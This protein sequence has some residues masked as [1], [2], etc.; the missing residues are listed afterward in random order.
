MKTSK[1]ALT[2]ACAAMVASCG[3]T[4]SGGAPTG[5][6]PTPTPSSTPTP[7]PTSGTCSL[8]S[9][10]SWTLAQL[11]EWYLFPDLLDT[12]VNPANYSSVQSYIDALVKPARD[13]SRDRYFTYLTSIAEENAFFQQGAS[14]GFGIRL[15]Y[16]TAAR[17]VYVIEAFENAP[18]LGQNMDRG[19]ELL[20]IGT[21]EANLQTVNSLMANGGP[22]AVI[23]ALGPD[24]AGTT[25]VIRIR[26][27]SGID[28]TISLSK[29]EYALDPVSDRYGFKIINDGGKKVGYINL[30]TFID[31]AGPDLRSAYQSFRAAGVTELVIDLR[32]N[33]GGLISI[34]EFMGDMMGRDND[35]QVFD[36]I[37]FRASKSAN[38]STYRIN[39][40]PESIQP[41]KI[42]FITTR[43][44]ASASEMVINGMQPYLGNT[45]IALIGENTFGKPVGQIALDQAACDDRLRVI[46][47]RVENA[48]RNGDYYTGLASTIP[49]S[50]RAQDDLTAQLGDPNEGMLSV[51]LDFLAGRSCTPISGGPAT[52]QAVVD[53]GFL[54]REQPNTAQR[55]VPGIF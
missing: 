15:G 2:L 12:T 9:R 3:G 51:A 32:Y 27:A 24:T 44:T 14:A 7:T 5:N 29:A 28:R 37:T 23:N 1:I 42:A 33:G 26:D 46:A 43:G 20:A 10:Q 52:T 38:D 34:A 49:N 36:Y 41:T 54:Q 19:S 8:S 22:S 35:N 4:S 16:D 53:R 25:R 30:R 6:V 40:Q 45:S 18:A 31:T 17:R 47:L 48:N 50:C 55:N 39:A 13:A 21:S 11:N